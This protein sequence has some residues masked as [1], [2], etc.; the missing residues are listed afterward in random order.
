MSFTP[1]TEIPPTPLL[2]QI[3]FGCFLLV[4]GAVVLYPLGQ[5]LVKTIYQAWSNQPQPPALAAFE[6][7]TT[8]KPPHF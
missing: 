1:F 8:G 3:G 6:E 2:N 4:L 5:K 7:T